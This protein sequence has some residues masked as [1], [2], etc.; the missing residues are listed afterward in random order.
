MYRYLTF[1]CYGTL[2]DWRA[3][4]ERAFAFSFGRLPIAG[5]SLYQAYVTE[6][7][8][9]ESS[10]K[11]YRSVLAETAVRLVNRL[12]VNAG[13]REGREFADSLPAWPAFADTV[14]SLRKLGEMGYKRYILS[15]VDEDLLRETIAR[16]GLEIDGYV[17]AQETH[18]YKPAPGHWERFLVKTGARVAE[19]L[20]VAQSTFHDIRPAHGLGFATAWVNRYD[21]P[22]ALDFRPDYVCPG[23]SDLARVLSGDSRNGK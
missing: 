1:D 5:E 22:L 16:N 20:H 10:Y 2:I 23:L 3:G 19:D 18:S 9:Q 21:E 14:D 4:L 11:P 8:S 12:G 13:D 7:A 6:E 17:T 15:N